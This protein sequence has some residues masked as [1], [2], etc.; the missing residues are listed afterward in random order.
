M[1]K[2]LTS[3]TKSLFLGTNEKDVSTGNTIFE[4]A[5]KDRRARSSSRDVTK[6]KN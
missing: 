2:A 6:S 5:S 3:I 1:E 4:D